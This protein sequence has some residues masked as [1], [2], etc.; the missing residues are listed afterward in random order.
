MTII[1]REFLETEIAALGQQAAQHL[2]LHHM[3][4]GAVQA[5]QATLKELNN[6]AIPVEDIFPGAII[7]KV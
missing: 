4:N 6:G 2:A 1:T 7:E 5:L 3:A